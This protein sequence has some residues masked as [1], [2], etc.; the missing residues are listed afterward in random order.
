MAYAKETSDL[1]QA[2]G[3]KGY[4]P[5]NIEAFLLSKGH[6]VSKGGIERHLGLYRDAKPDVLAA[7]DSALNDTGTD[8][9]KPPAKVFNGAKILVFDIETLPNRG[10]FF[11]IYSDRGI[12]LQ[13][14]E[15]PKC[16]CTAAYK[17]L[18]DKE[19]HV[20]VA[21]SPY[22][23]KSILEDFLP[24]YEQADYVV[25]HYGDGFDIPFTAARLAANGLPPLPPV[26]SIDTYKLAKKHFGKTLNSNRLDHLGEIF[27]VG[28]KNK[29]DASLWVRCANGE[30]E[31][32]K[33]MALYNM[34]DVDL[35]EKVFLKLLPYVKSKL[36]LNLFV[37]DAVK[38]CKACG[39]ENLSH[40]GFQLN[41]STLHDRCKC[42]DC[43]SWS[44]FKAAKQ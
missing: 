36:N 41:A 42:G 6:K 23:D 1:I 8:I 40:V 17:W 14:V 38:R 5:R 20:L 31:A 19:T 35:L 28:K 3:K 10:F 15:K 44:S 27:G 16:I 22:D 11:D 26:T 30:P 39:S 34:Q 37:D 29:T 4:S 43:G 25:G 12:A 33:E 13:F 2:L 9:A 24:V 32:L 7:M 18:G 21:S